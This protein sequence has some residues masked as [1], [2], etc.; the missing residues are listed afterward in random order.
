MIRSQDVYGVVEGLRLRFTGKK[1]N[2]KSMYFKFQKTNATIKNIAANLA[3]RINSSHFTIQDLKCYIY[4]YHIYNDGN[5][6]F[7]IKPNDVCESEKKFFSKISL[8]ND[9]KILLEINKSTKFNNIA[10]YFEVQENGENYASLLIFNKYISPAFYLKYMGYQKT[11]K[12][13]NKRQNKLTQVMQV[14]K[15]EITNG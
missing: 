2:P 3:S 7:N 10:K 11:D 13:E 4:H 12:K 1:V 14:I 9:K 15:G 6:W 5:V 8:K